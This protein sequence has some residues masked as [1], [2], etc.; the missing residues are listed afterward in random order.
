MKKQKYMTLEDESLRSDTVQ[1][2]TWEEQRAITFSSTRSETAG[3]K[4]NNIKNA[5]IK[6]K[7]CFHE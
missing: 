7:K 6:F 3:Q 2:T 5:D 4:P 1:Y